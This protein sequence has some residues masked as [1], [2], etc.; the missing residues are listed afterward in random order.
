MVIYTLTDRVLL[1]EIIAAVRYQEINGEHYIDLTTT[2]ELKRGDLVCV[3]SDI[4]GITREYVVWSVDEPHEQDLI[5]RTYR[6]VWSLQGIL[7]GVTSSTMPSNKTAEQALTSLLTDTDAF[8]IGEVEP[9]TTASASFWRMTAWEGLAVLVDT[10][11]GEVDYTYSNGTRTI[12]LRNKIGQEG[13]FMFYYGSSQIEKVTRTMTDG[14]NVCRVI[15]LGAASQTD[16]G[17]YGR[18]IDITS[19]NNNKPYLEDAEEAAKYTGAPN[20][21]PTAY[22]ENSEIT[23]PAELKAW[24]QTVLQ[25]ITRPQPEYSVELVE[26][27]APMAD[28]VPSLGDTG[29]IIDRELGAELEARVYA[30]TVDELAGSVKATCSTSSVGFGA[31][32][33]LLQGSGLNATTGGTGTTSAS[34][35]LTTTQSP[36]TSHITAYDRN[37]YGHNTF[38]RPGGNLTIGAGEFADNMKSQ[39]IEGCFS[40]TGENLH[41][42]AD[43]I[44]YLYSNANTIADRKCWLINANGNIAPGGK[45]QGVY[46]IDSSG[47]LYPAFYD[48]GS[49]FWI[50]A[51]RTAARHHKGATYISSGHNGTNGNATAYISV[52]NAANDNA[53][54]YGIYHAGNKPSLTDLGGT[55]GVNHGGTGATSAA[56]ARAALDIMTVD[57]GNATASSV[58]ASGY[59]DVPVTF[60]K[61]FTSAPVVVACLYT[62]A[63]TTNYADYIA[64]VANTT[65]TGATI[66]VINKG[67]TSYSPGVR[68]IAVGQ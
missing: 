15:P 10:W 32:T 37:V 1:D 22:I 8:T 55:L 2:R 62:T 57:A 64:V 65:N 6:C 19:V 18:K 27:Y 5:A 50:G 48:N 30:M 51:E 12:N 61:T 4:D 40:G 33:E 34:V 63:T 24:G 26:T 25:T 46:Q 14:V 17:G 23:D 42:G 11:G 59:L 20:P 68:W 49:N 3:T 31:L 66:R 21:Y 7:S 36:Y 47:V 28:Y 38:W 41:L 45:A 39:D 44:V 56:G 53:T 52:P 43:G 9:T 67:T 58:P 54:N 29:T 60:S 16:T 35:L 13:A